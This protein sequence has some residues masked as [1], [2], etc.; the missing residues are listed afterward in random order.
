VRA[1]AVRPENSDARPS[2]SLLLLMALD[3]LPD[4]GSRDSAR[5]C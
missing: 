2:W 3:R 4:R 5:S 1:H